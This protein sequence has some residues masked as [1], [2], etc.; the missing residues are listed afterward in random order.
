MEIDNE[1]KEFEQQ[2]TVASSVKN[3]IELPENITN[4]NI[5]TSEMSDMKTQISQL[6]S[7][8]EELTAKVDTL[9]NTTETE[10]DSTS[11]DVSV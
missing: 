10:S 7:Y 1:S 11:E 6:S 5:L 8:V 2:Y 3:K 4:V 9:T